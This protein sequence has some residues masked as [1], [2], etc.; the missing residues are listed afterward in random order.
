MDDYERSSENFLPSDAPENTKNWQ[1]NEKI[2]RLISR[3]HSINFLQIVAGLSQMFLGMAVVV[4]SVLGLIQP[5]WLSTVMSILASVTTMIGIYFCY[6]AISTFDSDTLLR[7][8]MRRI[9]EEQ[10]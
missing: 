3:A 8:A 9:I 1:R 6:A 5:F 2:S 10:N 7:N 4:I